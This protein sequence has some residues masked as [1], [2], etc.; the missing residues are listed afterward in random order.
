MM[1]TTIWLDKEVYLNIYITKTLMITTRRIHVCSG[2]QISL[3]Y[4]PVS[5]TVSTD[6][7]A[8]QVIL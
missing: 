2:F 3:I 1:I 8:E 7:S 5:Y 6:L 4:I